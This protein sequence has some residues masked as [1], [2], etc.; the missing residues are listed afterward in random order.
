MEITLNER[1]L[2]FLST[3][4]LKQSEIYLMKKF[5]SQYKLLDFDGTGTKTD[6]FMKLNEYLALN[7]YKP[8]KHVSTVTKLWDEPFIS[9]EL[10]YH[11]EK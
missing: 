7:G 5:I 10:P 9:Y 6:C 11:D 2:N 3:L 8:K 1:E 4:P